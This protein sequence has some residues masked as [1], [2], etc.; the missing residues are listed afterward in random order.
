[1]ILRDYERSYFS[2]CPWD[3]LH[4]DRCIKIN[5]SGQRFELVLQPVYP[6]VAIIIAV[7]SNDL[8]KYEA[9]NENRLHF[10]VSR[11][12]QSGDPETLVAFT[13]DPSAAKKKGGSERGVEREG[14]G[15]GRARKRKQSGVYHKAYNAAQKRM[16]NFSM[17]ASEEKFLAY[18]TGTRRYNNKWVEGI[19][20]RYRVTILSEG[21]YTEGSEAKRT[22]R[23]KEWQQSL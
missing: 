1:M 4:P 20:P 6:S 18:V 17:D 5:Y 7:A 22:T 13:P 2:C 3:K 15:Q 8:R 10:T 21:K 11:N 12:F 19:Y 14:G 23:R 9:T 16:I